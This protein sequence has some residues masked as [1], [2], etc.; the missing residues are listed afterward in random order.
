MRRQ[1]LSFI[2]AVLV[3]ACAAGAARADIRIKQRV[4]FGG[5]GGGEGHAMESDVAIKGQRQR[6]EQELAPGMKVVSI[7]QC[8]MKRLLNVSDA[9]RKYTVTPLGGAEEAATSP[10]ATS[11]PRTPAGRPTRGGVVTFV[12]TMTDTGERKQMFGYAARHIIMKVRTE[13]SPDA[14]DREDMAYETDGWYI[15]LEFNFECMMNQRP[16]SRQSMQPTAGCQDAMR[17]RRVGTAKLG[18]PVLVTTRYFGKDGKIQTEMTQEIV[19]LSRATLD[20][21]LFDVPA[22]YAETQNPQELYDMAGMMQSMQRANR[23]ADESGSGGGRTQ[24]TGSSGMMSA[25]AA[26]GAKQPGVIRVGVVR[27][28]NKTTQSVDAGNL[29]GTLIAAISEGGVEAI[30]LTETAPDA[31]Q[32]EA[33]QKECDYVLFTDVSGLKQSTANKL[34][35]MLGRATGAS[36]GAERYEAKLDYTLAP[37]AGG[38]P[39]QANVAAKEDGGADVSLNAALRREGQAVNAKVRK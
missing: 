11:T 33:K 28:G 21:A 7:T 22:G 6:S 30:P 2:S 27:V 10:T 16:V 20:A 25:P 9:T 39:V 5:Q 15:D 24:S 14:C 29:R 23:D 38:A 3:L 4:T 34:G 36:S 8:D 13:H 26:S 31:A 19:S 1:L 12:Q 32:A 37:V 35:G 18:Y 17:F